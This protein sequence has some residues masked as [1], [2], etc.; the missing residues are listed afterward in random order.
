MLLIVRL[1]LLRQ[2]VLMGTCAVVS[3]AIADAAKE[4]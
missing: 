2:M 3:F 1:I 4:S